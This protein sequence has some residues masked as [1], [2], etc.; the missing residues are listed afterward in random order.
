MSQPLYF[1]CICAA[2]SRHVLV[3]D[4]WAHVIP[5]IESCHNVFAQYVERITC[6]QLLA[7]SLK[8]VRSNTVVHFACLHAVTVLASDLALTT[9]HWPYNIVR[10][11][12]Q[13]SEL[14]GT[15]A[16]L[17]RLGR[18]PS[19]SPVLFPHLGRISVS[20]TVPGV[21]GGC[22]WRSDTADEALR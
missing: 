21:D 20:E 3:S 15:P 7:H 13:L 17:R 6:Y 1:R 11:L 16:C 2:V 14:F 9:S 4:F 19:E 10:L 22:S 12:P 8:C 18:P 5:R